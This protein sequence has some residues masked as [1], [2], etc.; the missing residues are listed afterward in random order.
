VKTFCEIYLVRPNSLFRMIIIPIALCRMGAR[1][2]EKKFDHRNIC[3]INQKLHYFLSKDY[4]SDDSSFLM[5]FNFK[6]EIRFDNMKYLKQ[7]F[8]FNFIELHRTFGLKNLRDFIFRSNKTFFIFIST[9]RR[10]IYPRFHFLENL[11]PI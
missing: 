8:L 2:S 11:S 5:F 7:N 3:C 4:N 10:N 6:N 9:N 1:S